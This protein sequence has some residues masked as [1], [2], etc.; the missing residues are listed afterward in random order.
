[1]PDTDNS[2]TFH[3]NCSFEKFDYMFPKYVS[4]NALLRGI[5]NKFEYEYLKK[6]DVT[7]DLKSRNEFENW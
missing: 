2:F 6:Y 5:R 3:E 1:M 7:N 4:D